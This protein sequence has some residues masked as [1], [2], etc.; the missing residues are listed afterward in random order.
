MSARNS[1]SRG[2]CSQ[3]ACRLLLLVLLTMWAPPARGQVGAAPRPAQAPR[4]R[5]QVQARRVG[6]PAR[7]AISD[8]QFDTW[9]FREDHSAEAARR[10]QE[11]VLALKMEEIDRACRLTEQQKQKLQLTGQG[12]IKRFFDKYESLKEKA[13]ATLD[14]NQNL[15]AVFQETTP[16]ASTL[17]VGLFGSGSLFQRSFHTTLTSAQIADYDAISRQRIGFRH[18][19]NIDLVVTTL[20]ESVP[21]PSVQRQKLVRFLRQELKAPSITGNYDFYYIMWQLGTIP[22]EKLKP[23]F[24]ATQW[25]IVDRFVTQYKG[26]EPT[27]RQAGYFKQ[28]NGEVEG[29]DADA[30]VPN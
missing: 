16:L 11:S 28:P 2:R 29:P 3:L 10:R 6:Q 25:R 30:I 22:E 26:M 27:L 17:Q 23:F 5:G 14:G 9:V 15:N 7:R 1:Y 13:Y 8:Q 4:A 20:E 19:A 21:L 24:D 18:N 12:D